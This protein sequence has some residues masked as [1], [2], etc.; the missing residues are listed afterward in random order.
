M[1]VKRGYRMMC[2]EEGLSRYSD[3]QVGSRDHCTS[4]VFESFL[5]KL[6]SSSFDVIKK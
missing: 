2:S 3:L 4:G 6:L 5:I 1:H